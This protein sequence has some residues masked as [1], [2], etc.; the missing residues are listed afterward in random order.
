V[1]NAL[2]DHVP[3]LAPLLVFGVVVFVH[4][5][6]HF[7]AAKATGVYAPRFSIGFGPALWHHR[8]GETEYRLS[9]LPFGGYVR[10]ASRDDEAAAMLEGG[11]E[12]GNPAEG[13]EWDPKAMMPFGPRPIP[14]NRW[15]ESKPL[16]ARL[17]IMLAG[18]TMNLLLAFVVLT[19]L[20]AY[21]GPP[22]NA[23]FNA[24]VDSV[25]PKSAAAQAGLVAGDS[26]A[27]I[28]GVAVRSA[29]DVVAHVTPAIGVPLAIDVVRHGVKQ[30]LTATPVAFA[31]TDQATHAVKTIGRL[32]FGFRR[33]RHPVSPLVAAPDGAKMTV[34]VS[35]MIFDQ[36]GLLLTGR[37]SLKTLSGPVRIAQVSVEA[38]RSGFE[39]LLTLLAIISINVA[40]F[41]LL[42]IPILDGGQV[43]VNVAESIKG[44]PFS[45]R[46]RELVVRTGL[47]AIAL[48]VM[49][50]MYNDRCVLL[51]VFVPGLCS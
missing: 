4:E 35:K 14:E 38:A 28:D 40:I 48:L 2:R 6:G 10:M 5:L 16:P 32:G 3:W 31:D 22:S 45:L 43:V 13:P 37:V 41:N 12:E 47:L 17:V 18:V 33:T 27:S 29:D 20:V 49:L 30:T 23:P 9:V 25:T 50:V 15:F 36:L 34:E 39:N 7:L 46:T 11:P 19:G 26:I 51:H 44:S 8:W 1:L 42:P 21:Y 24:V